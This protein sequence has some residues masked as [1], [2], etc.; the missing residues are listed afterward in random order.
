MRSIDRGAAGAAK[1]CC[2]VMNLPTSTL[3]FKINNVS[4]IKKQ[5][6]GNR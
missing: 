5:C 6:S 3:T 1:T 4:G 2:A